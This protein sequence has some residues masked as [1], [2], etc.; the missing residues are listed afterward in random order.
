MEYWDGSEEFEPSDHGVE[1]DELAKLH[2]R[3]DMEDE[4]LAY[5]REQA[6]E[7]YSDFET[8]NIHNAI[9]AVFNLIETKDLTIDEVN[10]MI[11]NMIVIFE[12]DEAFEKCAVCVK[13][14]TGVNAKV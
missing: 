13:I 12:M 3:R 5:A 2:A 9:E 7:F 8:L 14:K 4:R 6:Y 10:E 11:D 1:E